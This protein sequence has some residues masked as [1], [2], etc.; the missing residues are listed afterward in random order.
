MSD[1]TGNISL[2]YEG[3]ELAYVLDV[4]LDIEKE[5]NYMVSLSFM[6]NHGMIDEKLIDLWDNDNYLMEILYEGVIIPWE[7]NKSIP[8]SE[9]FA[10]LL[11]VKGVKLDDFAGIKLLIDKGIELDFFQ[12]YYERKNKKE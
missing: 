4:G 3:K 6:E 2:Q 9:A 11:Q 1:I 7:E 10:E 12:E 8:N 5:T